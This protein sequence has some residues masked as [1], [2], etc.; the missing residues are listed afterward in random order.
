MFVV[1]FGEE[2]IKKLLKANSWP[3]FILTLLVGFPG[4]TEAQ[5]LGGGQSY[6]FLNT[7]FSAR[8]T[9]LFQQLN[10]REEDNNLAVFNP[11]LLNPQ[12]DQQ[13]S[14]S[15]L[16]HFDDIQS[17]SFNFSHHL[18]SSGITWHTGVHFMNYGDF[19][20]TDVRGVENGNFNASDLAW[21][22]GVGYQLYE[23]MAV[24]LNARWIHSNYDVFNSSAL[25]FDAGIQYFVSEKR[26]SLALVANNFGFVLSEF[27]DETRG[28]LP[29]NVQLAFSKRFEHLPFRYSIIYQHLEDWDLLYDDQTDETNAGGFILTE[30][31]IEDGFFDILLLHF[32]VNAELLLGKRET[33]RLRASYNHLRREE[34]QLDN[35]SSGAGF[36]FGV[37]IRIS[38]FRLD[39]GR[40]LF[41]QAGGTNHLS[42][43]TNLNFFR[44]QTILSN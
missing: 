20:R 18:D 10:L 9:A 14:F 30:N 16:F 38:K 33:I 36:S 17:G 42:F 34:L 35:F 29:T 28:R 23:R 24:G 41:H 19:V 43:S 27:T 11:A 3:I 26:M 37:G 6:A 21:H 15:T 44:D 39:Y 7:P 25:G 12:M 4:K 5:L 40:S 1:Q 8:Q 2:M 32:V 13:I 22:V 31:Q